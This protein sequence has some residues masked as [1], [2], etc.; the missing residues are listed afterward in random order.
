M[1][2]TVDSATARPV[3]LWRNVSFT[4]MW[5]S[6]AAS[7]FGDRM[8]M[9]AALVLLGG[10]VEG[11]D[12][13]S[14]N[15]AINFW[16]FL[17][18]L[19][20]SL[21]GGWLA[22]RLPRKWL[23]LACDEARAALLLLAFLMVGHLSGSV[24]PDAYQ[25]RVMAIL[26]GV[27]CFA[28]IFSPT[29]NA[30]IPQIIPLRQLQPG[31]ALLVSIAAIAS[32]IGMLVGGYIID[33]SDGTSVRTG[34][35]MGLLFYAASGLFFAFLR[36]RDQ[37]PVS[38]RPQHEFG[39]ATRYIL[40]HRRVLRLVGMNILV[41]GA[42]MV[43]F[44]AV[45]SLSRLSYDL[46]ADK[47]LVRY[48]QLA[49]ML[50]LGMIA[51]AGVVA[52]I[53]TRRESDLV[54]MVGI[55]GAGLSTLL[56]AVT[57]VFTLG[58]IF[59]FGVGL[60]GNVTLITIT[61]LLQS[62]APNYIRGRVMGLSS[63]LNTISNVAINF[64]IWQVPHSDRGIIIVCALMGPA[65]VLLGVVG[66]V[67]ALM[68]GPQ[69]TAAANVLWRLVRLYTLVWHRLEWRGRHHIPLT[70]GVVLAANHTTG[71]DPLLLQAATPRLIR[72]L[73]LTS[74]RFA[75]LEPILWRVIR[76]VTLDKEES[77]RN[78][79]RQLV[80]AVE[81]GDMIGM[82]PEG[83]L[84]REHRELGEFQPGIAMIV[85]R[86]DALILPA[87]IEGTPRTHNMLGHF[88][89]PSRSR[90]TFGQPYRP[91]PKQRPEEILAELRHRIEA[92]A[93]Y[94]ASR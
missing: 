62:I 87:F 4:L 17:P 35:M 9:L 83:G 20:L 28:A 2:A 36:V 78:K 76:P 79:I 1:Q 37:H 91:D 30:I 53:R 8:I 80:V 64:V 3:P 56:L 84:Q 14:V 19:L 45:L 43:V 69:V 63:M 77:D 25:W 66:L 92:L 67:R 41:W 52:A 85:R 71:L 55:I 11:V 61:S 57:P 75:A 70:G 81:Q 29:R 34:L 5:T 58:M 47:Q 27:G 42:A 60:F 74:Y 33:E 39:S 32:M 94:R 73:M 48:T 88:L 24:V 7:G 22:D 68:R 49:T 59:A 46:P 21:V 54:M 51:G 40:S 38:V 26:F 6:T 15:A 18:Y 89:R 93:P 31:N 72:W 13:V 50:G 44:Q 82:F 10:F 12:R 65:L 90:V 16:F 86:S 23:L